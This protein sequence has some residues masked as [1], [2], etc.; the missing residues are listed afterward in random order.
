M[1]WCALERL[2]SGE[3]IDIR[4]RPAIIGGDETRRAGIVLAKSMSAKRYGI[5]TAETIY[6]A[7]RKCPKLKVFPSCDYKTYKEYSNKL[8]NMLLEY[9]DKIERFSI[10]ECF[11][12]MTRVFDERYYFK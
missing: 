8:Y 11:M 3:T 4:E 6:S 5:K 10:D 7:K 1:S 2:K 9:T 12:D